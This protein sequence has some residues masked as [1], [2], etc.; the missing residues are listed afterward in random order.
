MVE[1]QLFRMLPADIPFTT[2]FMGGRK[3]VIYDHVVS[4][5]FMYWP[6]GRPC[7]AVNMYFLSMAHLTTG[8]SLKAYASQ[9]THLVRY[10]YNLKIN[11]FDLTDVHFFKLSEFLREQRNK[12]DNTRRAR[13]KNTVISVFQR[14]IHFLF[15]YQENF[16]LVGFK[17]LIGEVERSPQ[18]IVEL[19]NYK[20]FNEKVTVKRSQFYYVHRAMPTRESREPKHPISVEIIEGIEEYIDSL[21]VPEESEST[22]TQRNS[23][24][25]SFQ[26][27][28]R[29][30]IRSRRHFMIWLMKRTGL[31]PSEMV[32]ISV[33][34]HLDILHLKVIYIPTKKRRRA[35]A[36]LRSFPIT[37]KDAATF[38]RYLNSRSR[39]QDVLLAVGCENRGG[40]SLFIRIDGAPIK[41]VSLESDFK[42]LANA[43]GFKDHQAC[44]SMFRHRFITLEVLVH[45]KEFMK[46][47]GKSRRMM[48]DSDYESILKRVAVKTGHSNVH[49]LWHYIDIAWS[50]IDVWGGVD[51]AITRLHAADRLYDELLA[52]KSELET[53]KGSAEVTAM[54]DNVINQLR[55]IMHSVREDF[56]TDDLS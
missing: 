33:R 36:P 25:S 45:I 14:V 18:I 40:D 4:F 2:I 11:F 52:L 6:D 16:L 53:R 46:G 7:D 8:D 21:R 22:F 42:R 1:V 49:S 30:Y 43:A 20:I 37:L 47:T 28:K 48:T 15:W 27:A 56:Y 34:M 38:Q 29:E 24:V 55:Q 44:F 13:N 17:T 35:V 54:L 31:R 3:R 50:E 5:P 12:Y 9:L 41:K 39:Y 23:S 32:D 51:R 10:C 26:C 19:K